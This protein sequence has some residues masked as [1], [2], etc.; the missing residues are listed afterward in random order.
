VTRGCTVISQS[1]HRDSEQTESAPSFDDIYKDY[2]AL[3]WPYPTILHAA[4]NGSSTEFVNHKG[5]NTLTVGSH[6]DTATAMAG[7]SVF[8]N[9]ASTHSDR[10]LP[11]L[12]ANGTAV[13]LLGQT[14]SGTSFAAPAAAGCTA[15]MQE[16]D[17]TLQSWPEGCR[18]ILLAG[19]SKNVAGNTW[20]TDRS[21]A[22]DARDGSGSVIC[23]LP[24]LVLA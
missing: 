14:M 20:W 24:D 10:E 1:F 8:R 16:A 21:A 22:V 9:P 13:T 15:L 6:D 19:A 7:D 18:A 12:A 5:Y 2:L 11:E 23:K 4:G 17:A 3:Q